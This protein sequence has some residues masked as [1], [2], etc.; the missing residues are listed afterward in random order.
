MVAPNGLSAIWDEVLPGACHDKDCR[1]RF[2]S[3]DFTER[4]CE[5]PLTVFTGHIV[6]VCTFLS[7]PAS[8]F[9]FAARAFF[10]ATVTS[11]GSSSA[12]VASIFLF[13]LVGFGVTGVSSFL[14]GSARQYSSQNALNGA[15]RGA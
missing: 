15:R 11:G 6:T 3:V 4:L 5:P 13:R 9:V 14:D 7:G 1:Y 8:V 10:L 12:T 2:L